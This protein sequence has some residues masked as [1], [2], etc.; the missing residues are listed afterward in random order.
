MK[1]EKRDEKIKNELEN[2]FLEEEL[3][4]NKVDNWSVTTVRK[5][6]KKL[7]ESKAKF[8][9]LF[10]KAHGG[11]YQNVPEKLDKTYCVMSEG[12]KKLLD[13]DDIKYLLKDKKSDEYYMIVCNS[14]YG[15]GIVEDFLHT[16]INLTSY[17]SVIPSSELKA[18]FVFMYSDC[19][20]SPGWAENADLYRFDFADSTYGNVEAYQYQ[21]QGSRINAL[22]QETRTKNLNEL[23]GLLSRHYQTLKSM[24]KLDKFFWTDQTFSDS[25]TNAGNLILGASKD[26]FDHFNVNGGSEW[27]QMA[28]KYPIV[29]LLW[30]VLGQLDGGKNETPVWN[31]SQLVYGQTPSLS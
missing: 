18:N 4:Y 7:K 31:D 19:A 1:F 30:R 14:C 9:V 10:I 28:R 26:T 25:L 11:K 22:I 15:G 12:N 2:I 29:F 21:N 23:T 8:K 20:N 13:F 3:Q 16:D 24:L 6:L 5:E 17:S 27:N